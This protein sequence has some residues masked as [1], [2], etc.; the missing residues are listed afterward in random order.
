MK[1]DTKHL[2]IHF[3][4][5]DMNDMR[6]QD[7]AFESSIVV[8]HFMS[9]LCNHFDN[10]EIE[11]IQNNEFDL[12][13]VFHGD[14]KKDRSIRGRVKSFFGRSVRE[15]IYKNQFF[16]VIVVNHKSDIEENMYTISI[17]DSRYHTY[18]L[19]IYVDQ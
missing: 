17:F 2:T 7:A 6:A 3:D 19:F 15:L 18:G 1:D 11:K 8:S 14:I 13:I 16:S 5:N 10:V 4:G 9:V 12:T